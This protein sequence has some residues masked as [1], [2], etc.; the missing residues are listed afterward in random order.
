MKPRRDNRGFRRWPIIKDSRGSEIEIHES[1][2]DPLGKFMWLTAKNHEPDYRESDAGIHLRKGDIRRLI[3][4]LED[5]LGT[6][7]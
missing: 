3:R 7:P 2:A 5:A 4:T 1:S 6:M